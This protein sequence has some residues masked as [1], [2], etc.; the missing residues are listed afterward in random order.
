MSEYH[1]VPV[2]KK[3][4][5]RKNVIPKELIPN[6]TMNIDSH[7]VEAQPIRDFLS[8]PKKVTMTERMMLQKYMPLLKRF[9]KMPV[10]KTKRFLHKSP[11]MFKII[12]KICKLLVNGGIPL[13]RI[14][15]KN[16]SPLAVKTLRDISSIK[17]AQLGVIRNYSGLEKTLKSVLPIVARFINNF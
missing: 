12:K 3:L 15:R 8:I 11:V 14:Q 2:G 9:V 17:S 1:L 13:S 5:D 6:N 7:H 4:D 16:L 10:A